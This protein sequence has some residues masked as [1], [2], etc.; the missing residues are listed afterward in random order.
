[1]F[2]DNFYYEAVKKILDQAIASY[3]QREGIPTEVIDARIAEHIKETSEEHHNPD[4]N[5]NYRLPLCRLGYLFSHAGA[6][7]CLFERTIRDSSALSDRIEEKT[8]Q[9]LYMCT[10]GGGPGTELLGLTKYL[11]FRQ[12]AP[13][14]IH[15]KV[16]DN[17]V[18][19]GESWEHLARI[20][21]DLLNEKPKVHRYFY[22]VDATDRHNFVDLAW[23]FEN[24][25][26]IVLN[27]F[28][29]ENQVR[30]PD[31]E[32]VLEILIQRTGDHGLFVIID[33]LERNTTFRQDVTDLFARSCLEIVEQDEI[34]GA[35]DDEYDPLNEY[36]ERFGDR[37]PRKWFRTYQRHHPTAFWFVAQ[38]SSLD[39]PF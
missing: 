35:M 17:I 6:N 31:F 11:L 9:P 1:M 10:I 8:N 28:L 18:Q 30:I 19:W 21:E 27:Y 36:I 5:I 4:P 38:K 20:S 32:Q 26:I 23:L 22:S 37:K 25:D 24:V 34:G 16:I 14:D 39:L 2:Y 12:K 3:S 33:R 13:S 7:A 15:F 29:S